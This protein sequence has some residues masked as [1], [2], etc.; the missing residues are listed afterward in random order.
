MHLAR[1][2]LPEDFDVRTP[3]EKAPHDA[4]EVA[5]VAGLGQE[6]A[7][8]AVRQLG[9]E[10]PLDRDPRLAEER[11][12]VRLGEERREGGVEAGFPPGIGVQ[13]LDER[14]RLGGPGA[15][16]AREPDEADEGVD[17]V[18]DLLR[19]DERV[20]ALPRLPKRERI[21]EAISSS[22]PSAPVWPR[23]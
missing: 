4:R 14:D 8:D 12:R 23:P 19:P 17:A 10:A 11:R 18:A 1:V 2:A 15:A 3:T 22:A 13:G 7:R 16:D 5:V 20:E 21:H 6:A 9:E